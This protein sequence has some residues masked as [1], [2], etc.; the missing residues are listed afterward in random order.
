MAEEAEDDDT[1]AGGLIFAV[2]CVCIFRCIFCPRFVK[3]RAMEPCGRDAPLLWRLL[4]FGWSCEPPDQPDAITGRNPS[5]PRQTVHATVG[6]AQFGE[7][8][9]LGVQLQSRAQ[10][11]AGTPSLSTEVLGAVAGSQV[12][13]RSFL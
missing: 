6:E 12:L 9:P 5:Q 3:Y 11:T 4:L 7:P 1:P 8:G 2:V 10:T 13:Q